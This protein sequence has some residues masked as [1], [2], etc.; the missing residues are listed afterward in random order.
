MHSCQNYF[1]EFWVVWLVIQLIPS[2]VTTLSST[3][4]LHKHINIGREVHERRLES[5][6]CYA[7]GIGTLFAQTFA[8]EALSLCCRAWRLS[9]LEKR[10]IRTRSR[11]GRGAELGEKVYLYLF[12]EINKDVMSFFFPNHFSMCD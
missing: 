4:S 7:G 9:S 1:F 8:L 6:H 12:S 11:F 5:L 2:V 10:S 3:L